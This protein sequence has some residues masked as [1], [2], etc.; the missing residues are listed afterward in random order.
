MSFDSSDQVGYDFVTKGLNEFECVLTIP[1]KGSV[2]EKMYR[3]VR[4]SYTKIKKKDLPDATDGVDHF[5]VPPKMYPLIKISCKR[6]FKKAWD[7][8]H[9]DGIKVLGF[10]VVKVFFE[11]VGSHWQVL[12]TAEGEYDRQY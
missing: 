8:V 12:V 10:G 9:E 5:D 4:K 2:M 7:D 6:Y 1:V 3:K 11:R